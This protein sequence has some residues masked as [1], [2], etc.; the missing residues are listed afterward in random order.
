MTKKYSEKLILQPID[1]V[2]R[3]K[4]YL[5]MSQ[6]NFNAKAVDLEASWTF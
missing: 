2:I 6:P 3:K 5:C 4:I 1:I